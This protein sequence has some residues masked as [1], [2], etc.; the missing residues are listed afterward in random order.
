MFTI[1]LTKYVI[2]CYKKMLLNYYQLKYV[3]ENLDTIVFM[4]SKY[5]TWFYF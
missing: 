2:K 5:N 3:L 1:S 4:F